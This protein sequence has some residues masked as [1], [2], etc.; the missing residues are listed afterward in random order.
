MLNEEQKLES[1]RDRDDDFDGTENV[2]ESE[3][4]DFS[5]EDVCG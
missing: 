4:V 1:V 5:L 2:Q 3:E